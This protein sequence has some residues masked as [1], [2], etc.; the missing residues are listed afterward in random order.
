MPFL[1]R[2][3]APL[4]LAPCATACSPGPRTSADGGC[5][6]VDVEAAAATTSP[7]QTPSTLTLSAAASV[8]AVPTAEAAPEGALPRI[9]LHKGGC[10]CAL[11]MVNHRA[12]PPQRAFQ[13]PPHHGAN[14]YVANDALDIANEE[15]SHLLR[16]RGAYRKGGIRVVYVCTTDVHQSH[17]DQ[18]PQSYTPR[19]PC[20][21]PIPCASN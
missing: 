3:P 8:W 5:P 9:C 7:M 11:G 21:T 18:L 12:P 19:Y 15:G 4:R 2:P 17:V 14:H 1:Q 10:G 6:W 13:L 20:G 16:G